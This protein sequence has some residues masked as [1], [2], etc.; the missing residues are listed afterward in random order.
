MTNIEDLYTVDSHEA[1]AEMQVRDENGN[2]LKMFITVAG[3]DS[4]LFRKVKVNLRTNLLKGGENV[5]AETIRAE[6]LAN[7]TLG[8]RGFKSKGK[9]L[10][11]S[12]ERVKQL[13]NSAPYVM[14]QVDKF[15]NKRVNFT[16]G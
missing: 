3:I 15:V 5:D 14:D 16:K 8:W 13:Y 7:V 12:V 1:G 6:A 2:K 10:E 4:K 11:F 9:K